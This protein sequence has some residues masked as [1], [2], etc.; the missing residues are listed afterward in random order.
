[1]R[2]S[3]PQL[4]RFF[5]DD[6][7]ILE[8]LSAASELRP[9]VEEIEAKVDELAERLFAAGLIADTHAKDGFYTCLTALEREYA[10]V[11]VLLHFKSMLG[12]RLAALWS[13]ERLL[14]VDEQFIGPDIDGH[15]VRGSS[16]VTR[17]RRR[18]PVRDRRPHSRLN[19]HDNGREG[20]QR[21]NFV[22]VGTQIISAQANDTKDTPN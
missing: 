22:R 16:T 18:R 1:M 15:P 20:K 14:N 21:G 6:F 19:Q 3:E 10:G 11:A 9:V 13:S 2:L 7:L 5:E 4:E 8:G 12:P 17:P